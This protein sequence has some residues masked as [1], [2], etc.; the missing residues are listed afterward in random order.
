MFVFF[1]QVSLS[2]RKMMMSKMRMRKMKRSTLTQSCQTLR[3]LKLF[4]H[5]LI[6]DFLFHLLQWQ[7][8]NLHHTCKLHQ[9]QGLRL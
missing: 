1:V 2:Q 9:S 6:P 5:W 8:S 4:T 7:L 3:M